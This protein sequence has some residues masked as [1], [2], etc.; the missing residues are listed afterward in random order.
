MTD[1]SKPPVSHDS[2]HETGA[3]GAHVGL[4]I[5]S[6]EL[7][8]VELDLQVEAFHLNRGQVLHGGMTS[9]LADAACGYA[10]THPDMPEGQRQAVTLSLNVQFIE[11]GQPGRR[12][13]AIGEKV[14]G[15]RSIFF[16]RCDVRDESGAL[17][18]QAEGTFR[19]V[20]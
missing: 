13:T 16:S 18:A 3:F 5:T 12:I 20:G 7:N 14:G 4:Q 9:T 8:R 17:L 6:W 1:S 10:G 2:T 15:G 11:P 19:Y